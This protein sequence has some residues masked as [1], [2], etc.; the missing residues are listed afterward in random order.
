MIKNKF[1]KG[2][3]LI[4]TIFAVVIF[5]LIVGALGAFQKDVFFFNDVL[6]IG[7]NNVTEARK[8]LRPFVGEVRG[9]QPSNLGA[10]AI[11]SATQKS[12]IFYT[13]ADADG[14]KERV[15][16]FVEGDTFKKGVI[17]PTGNPFVYSAANEKITSVVNDVIYDQT[18]FAYY[19]SNY[20]GTSQT[21]ALSF[22]VSPSDVRLI[23]I[24]LTVDSNP[25]RAPSLMTITTQSTV[26]NL[27]DNYED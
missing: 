15:R 12:F 21:P 19:D 22:P 9:A 16:Y 2:F 3:T 8:V 5:T 7:L 6:Q 20:N 14:L 1:K 18:N 11:E 25:G 24:D 4:E 13:D 26:R 27:K 10:S 23:R 17:V